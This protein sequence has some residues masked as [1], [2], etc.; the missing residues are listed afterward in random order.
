MINREAIM[1]RLDLLERGRAQDMTVILTR[2]DDLDKRVED[3]ERSLALIHEQLGTI[4]FM[5]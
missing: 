3:I 1:E 5:L 2:F 4:A